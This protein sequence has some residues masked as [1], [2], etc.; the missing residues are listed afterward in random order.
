MAHDSTVYP[1]CKRG[2]V[3]FISTANERAVKIGWSSN[4]A[5]RLDNL[6]AANPETLRLVGV[7]QAGKAKE[8][9]YHKRFRGQK[10][11]GEWY[12]LPGP[13]RGFLEMLWARRVAR[14]E[15]SK[16]AQKRVDSP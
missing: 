12:R 15:T 16:K 2:Y 5:K 10:I 3:Y 8:A 11:R 1:P 6:Q 7:V 13:I 9:E 4:I 14:W